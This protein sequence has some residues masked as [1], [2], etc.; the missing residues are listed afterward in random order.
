MEEFH[1]LLKST[2]DTMYA[3]K[4]LSLDTDYQRKI[5]QKLG[6]LARRGIITSSPAAR[7]L[8]EL[9][10]E[11]I[12]ILYRHYSEQLI[13]LHKESGKDWSPDFQN[14]AFNAVSK[15][16]DN[17]SN[18][19]LT[20]KGV[21]G[22]AEPLL[23]ELVKREVHKFKSDV[24]LELAKYKGLTQLKLQTTPKDLRDLTGLR[25]PKDLD[26]LTGLIRKEYFEPELE[27]ALSSSE[28]ARSISLIMA[29]IDNFKEVN[30]KYGHQQGDKVLSELSSL[31]KSIVLYKG[32]A[33]RYGGEEIAIIL[34]NFSL[35]EAYVVAERIRK[36]VESLKIPL[37][38]EP[39]KTIN[40]TISLGVSCYPD[41]ATDVNVLV[42]YADRAM[43]EAKQMEKNKTVIFKQSNHL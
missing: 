23:N 24:K 9:E 36:S 28:G 41:H 17:E 27:K 37:L 29:D 35:E 20:P 43:Y 8:S 7:E 21:L 39:A 31:V 2:V 22:S 34:D 6:D 32:S 13:R 40:V 26:G 12:K 30:D 38:H 33:F 10:L 25:T 42:K 14:F 18:K 19:L 1:N 11:R 16:I 15:I 5:R 4:K 3:Q